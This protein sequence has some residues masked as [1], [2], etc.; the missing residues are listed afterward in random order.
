MPAN[1]R[2]KN[3]VKRQRGLYPASPETLVSCRWTTP[4]R[5]SGGSRTP[6]SFAPNERTVRGSTALDRCLTGDH[7]VKKWRNGNDSNDSFSTNEHTSQKRCARGATSQKTSN[8]GRGRRPAADREGRA[9]ARA[10]S[11]LRASEVGE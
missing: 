2:R 1:H 9:F 4:V 3:R 7:C 11:A 5:R 10:R 8:T 6:H